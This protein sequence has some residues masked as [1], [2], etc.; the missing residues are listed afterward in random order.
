M[1]DPQGGN[2]G[3]VMGVPEHVTNTNCNV[4]GEEGGGALFVTTT[5]DDPEDGGEACMMHPNLMH[6]L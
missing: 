2:R 5:A 4:G 1:P 6:V 3:P